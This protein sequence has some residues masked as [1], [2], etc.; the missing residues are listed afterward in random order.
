MRR[1]IKSAK[2]IMALSG[3]RSSWLIV[4]RNSD[5][6]AVACFRVVACSPEF[7]LVLRQMLKGPSHDSRGDGPYDGEDGQGEETARHRRD[8]RVNQQRPQT[9]R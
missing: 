5:L 3:V 6:S 7:L 4:A 2:P 9:P 1:F 8:D